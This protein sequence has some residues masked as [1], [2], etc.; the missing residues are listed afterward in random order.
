M[1]LHWKEKTQ[2]LLHFRR[3]E[4]TQK[5]LHWTGLWCGDGR[6]WWWC[7]RRLGLLEFSDGKGREGNWLEIILALDFGDGIVAKSWPQNGRNRLLVNLTGSKPAMTTVKFA[8]PHKSLGIYTSTKGQKS[9][10]PPLL[11]E[12]KTKI[13]GFHH[14]ILVIHARYTKNFKSQQIPHTV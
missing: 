1:W 14:C 6:Q 3:Q 12:T 4:K 10:V 2:K 9:Q 8:E 11:Q 5:W 7:G 13:A